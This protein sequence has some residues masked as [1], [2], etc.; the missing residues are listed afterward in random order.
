M[1]SLKEPQYTFSPLTALLR[2]VCDYQLLHTSGA[3]FFLSHS[4]RPSSLP[5]FL[6]LLCHFSLSW[7]VW[8]FFNLTVKISYFLDVLEITYS[9]WMNELWS[10]FIYILSFH[11]TSW[12]SFSNLTSL[13]LSKWKRTL[14]QVKE[15]LQWIAITTGIHTFAFGCGDVV[16]LKHTETFRTER[17]LVI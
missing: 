16:F 13:C 5:A 17:Y 6:L 11:T 8:A 7:F 2:A 14:V 4:D 15:I 1:G 9:N 12:C 3:V 10:S